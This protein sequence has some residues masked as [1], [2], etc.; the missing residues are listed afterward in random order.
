MKSSVTSGEIEMEIPN[1]EDRRKFTHTLHV[2]A[3]PVAKARAAPVLRLVGL[4]ESGQE[5]LVALAAEHDRGPCSSPE[6]V[7][8]ADGQL[9]RN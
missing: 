7:V 4:P 8:D 1:S 9:R 6:D 5:D 2:L 3:R